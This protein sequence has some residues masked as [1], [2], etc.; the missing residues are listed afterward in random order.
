L[1]VVENMPTCEHENIND[2]ANNKEG[3]EQTHI[4]EALKAVLKTK[5]PTLKSKGKQPI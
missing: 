3:E 1:D 5:N 4:Q 2:N